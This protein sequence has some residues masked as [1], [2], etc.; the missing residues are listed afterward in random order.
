MNGQRGRSLS[1]LKALTYEY[2]IMTGSNIL[3]TDLTAKAR[4]AARHLAG[5]DD[6]TKAAALIG[7]A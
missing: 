6:A 4:S 2:Q 7:A 1:L 5:V 3:M